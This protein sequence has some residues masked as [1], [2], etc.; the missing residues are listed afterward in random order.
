M[1]IDSEMIDSIMAWAKLQAP[2]NGRDRRRICIEIS[3]ESLSHSS[4]TVTRCRVLTL[5]E[6][7]TYDQ[8][9]ELLLP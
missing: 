3:A 2:Q 9:A 8:I 5:R 7:V 1:I 6:L 4:L